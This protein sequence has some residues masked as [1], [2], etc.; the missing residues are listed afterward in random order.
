MVEKSKYYTPEIEE[1][2][3]GFEYERKQGDK[4]ITEIVEPLGEDFP[5]MGD[6]D[7]FISTMDKG[8]IRVKYLDKE[9]IESL[10][11]VFGELNFDKFTIGF[12]E[13]YNDG[14]EN[15][16]IYNTEIEEVRFCGFIKNRSELKKLM[17]QL[18]IK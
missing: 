1:F 6:F 2:H 8:Y 16:L 10:G 13:Y 14:E 5:D 4:I 18:G 17:Q 3:V 9:D 11:W 12:N 7:Y 15:I